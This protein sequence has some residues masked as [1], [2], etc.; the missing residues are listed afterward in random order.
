[1]LI[2]FTVF[3]VRLG[4]PTRELYIN[5]EGFECQFNCPPKE[6]L[7]ATGDLLIVQLKAESPPMVHV[8][9]QRRDLVAGRVMLVIDAENAIPIFLD[10]KPQR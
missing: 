2:S 10:A 1:M 6:I 9:T 5:D 7:L 3:R 8:G 4:A